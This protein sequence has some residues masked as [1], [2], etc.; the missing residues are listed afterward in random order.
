MYD[1]VIR[2]FGLPDRDDGIKLIEEQDEGM[3]Q[4]WLG[5]CYDDVQWRDA[6][7]RGDELFEFF[8]NDWGIEDV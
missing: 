7:K 6:E 5:Q 3:F 1:L 4:N 2:E 8:K